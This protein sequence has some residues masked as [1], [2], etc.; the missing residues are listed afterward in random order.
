MAHPHTEKVTS[1]SA[2]AIRS[3]L[4][5]TDGEPSQTVYA[6]HADYQRYKSFVISRQI[7]RKALGQETQFHFSRTPKR[8]L[9][10]WQPFAISFENLG[11]SLRTAMPDIMVRNGRLFLS[12]AAYDAL[13]PIIAEHGEFLP[14]TYEGNNGFIF[15]VLSVA[16]D[17][18]ETDKRP[19]NQ[20]D[21]GEVQSLSFHNNKI[22]KMAL[23]RTATD[24]YLEIYCSEALREAIEKSQLKGIKFSGDTEKIYQ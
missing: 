19:C 11:S 3:S 1:A 21:F 15:N 14:I 8:Y 16:E 10:D 4:L 18:F 13:S 7:V 2:S 22:E 9:N 6:I 5:I 23:F 12:I 17:V 24:G 20:N